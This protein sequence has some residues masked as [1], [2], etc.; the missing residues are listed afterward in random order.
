MSQG[1]LVGLWDRQDTGTTAKFG[2]PWYVPRLPMGLWD[3]QDTGTTAESSLTVLKYVLKHHL[4]FMLDPK[5]T[6]ITRNSQVPDR[7]NPMRFYQLSI[8]MLGCVSDKNLTQQCGFLELLEPG[9]VVLADC[10]FT[11]EEDSGIHEA[12]LEIS[13]LTCGKKQLSQKY[14]LFA[15]M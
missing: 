2:S 7:H 15:S 1:L 12:K 4:L 9:N 5:H 10:G 11:V 14:Q 8:T 3:R 13:T 6:R